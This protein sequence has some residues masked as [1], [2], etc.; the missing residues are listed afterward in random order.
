MT[1]N[2]L[3]GR[4]DAR[5]LAEWEAYDRIEPFGERMTQLMLGGIRADVVNSGAV[6]GSKV[7]KAEDYLPMRIEKKEQ[8]WQEQK[9]FMKRRTEIQKRKAAKG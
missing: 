7:R 1:V 4:I 6:Q 2:E 9:A 5:E 8:T 3:L